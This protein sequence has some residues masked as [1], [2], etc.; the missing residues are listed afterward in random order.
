MTN[1]HRQ[2]GDELHGGELKRTTLRERGRREK[3]ERGW[4]GRRRELGWGFIEI[5][6]ES[7]GRRGCFMVINGVDFNGG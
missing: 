1:G 2:F 4:A 7:R 6:R 5:G 3:R